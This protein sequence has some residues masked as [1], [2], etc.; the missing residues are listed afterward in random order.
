MTDQSSGDPTACHDPDLPE[1]GATW[2]LGFQADAVA[3]DDWLVRDR[4]GVAWLPWYPA[5][6]AGD[7]V[8]FDWTAQLGIAVEEEEE[9]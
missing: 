9:E 1:D 4:V 8:S 6:R 7:T 5:L 2:D 3:S